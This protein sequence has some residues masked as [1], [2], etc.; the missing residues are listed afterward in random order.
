MPNLDPPPPTSHG[1]QPPMARQRRS[2]FILSQVAKENFG[3]SA[4][5][6]ITPKEEVEAVTGAA[7]IHKIANSVGTNTAQGTKIAAT[8]DDDADP[9]EIP[10]DTEAPNVNGYCEETLHKDCYCFHAEFPQYKTKSTNGVPN[11]HL[12]EQISTLVSGL[13]YYIKA[14]GGLFSL[15]PYKEDSTTNAITRATD[16]PAYGSGLEDYITEPSYNAA[17]NQL[18][19]HA[20]ILT[21]I[22]LA[23][24]K[25]RQI[26]VNS[27]VKKSSFK[28]LVTNGFYFRSQQVSST[29]LFKQGWLFGSHAAD[30]IKDIRE[31][32]TA[33]FNE[34]GLPPTTT[35]GRSKVVNSK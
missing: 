33:F 12:K 31:Q 3:S 6:H 14:T 9:N 2:P 15:L 26:P 19:F 28:F 13:A 21:S 11:V 7:R 23:H 8:A 5:I 4:N 17:R 29:K 34:H 24:L 35:N 32:I 22:R 30:D 27:L 18:T 25:A 16:L 10:A 20:R 1:G